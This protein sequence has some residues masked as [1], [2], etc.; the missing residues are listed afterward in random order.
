MVKNKI[1]YALFFLIFT[2]FIFSLIFNSISINYLS[3]K[4]NIVNIQ[5]K[6][7][8]DNGTYHYYFNFIKDNKLIE[9]RTTQIENIPWDSINAKKCQLVKYRK[10]RILLFFDPI[11]IRLIEFRDTVKSSSDEIIYKNGKN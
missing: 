8:Y 3:Y 1:I 6:T 11:R 4:Y 2:I 7:V 10:E 9:G 5:E